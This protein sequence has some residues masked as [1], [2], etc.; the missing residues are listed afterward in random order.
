[1]MCRDVGGSVRLN[2]FR[3]FFGIGYTVTAAGTDR[4]KQA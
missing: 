2:R 1:M 3:A 4:V